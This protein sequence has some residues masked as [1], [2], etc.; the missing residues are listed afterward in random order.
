MAT[1]FNS[2][3][4]LISGTD[5]ESF[6]QTSSEKVERHGPFSTRNWR[7]ELKKLRS[8]KCPVI[9]VFK[10]TDLTVAVYTDL[11]RTLSKAAKSFLKTVQKNDEVTFITLSSRTTLDNFSVWASEQAK[12]FVAKKKEG[13]SEEEGGLEKERRSDEE[14]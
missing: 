5:F 11:R 1:K 10:S 4:P 2:R 9:V 13:E 7:K 12:K 8:K 3:N 6:L 14:E